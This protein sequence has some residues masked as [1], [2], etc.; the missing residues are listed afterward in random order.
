VADSAATV[1]RSRVLIGKVIAFLLVWVIV[2]AGTGA[3]NG[4]RIN[5]RRFY[6]M[7]TPDPA[8]S[9]QSGRF[10]LNY[11]CLRKQA[12]NLAKMAKLGP[13]VLFGALPMRQPPSLPHYG[14]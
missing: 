1:A 14:A 6:G 8:I 10:D 3:G 11:P 13:W 12:E 5:R 4:A 9:T 7:K 2:I